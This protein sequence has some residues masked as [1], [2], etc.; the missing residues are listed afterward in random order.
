MTGGGTGI[1]KA[2]AERFVRAGAN[3]VI[4]ARRDQTPFAKMIGA[5]FIQTDVRDEKSVAN[6]MARARTHHGSLDILVNNAGIEG[7]YVMIA[8]ASPAQYLECFASNTLG[9]ALGI[10]HAAAHMQAGGAIVNV[11][12]IAGVQGAAG[13][14]VYG[15]SKFGVVGLTKTAAIELAPRNIRVNCV[16]PG[17]VDTPMLA[18]EG[19]ESEV[20]VY[21]LLS[22]AGRVCGAEEVAAAIHFLCADDCTYI[23]GQAINMC[24]GMS[25]GVSLSFAQHAAAI[26][27][28]N[29]S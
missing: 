8:D 6:L 12:S 3:V 16:C 2:V 23:N 20:A 24:G 11:S 22:P 1:G 14:G 21:K 26:E 10:K 4:A 9:V 15:V 25:A 19:S 27:S 18:A 13:I 28:S 7:D 17:P 5:E 29:Q